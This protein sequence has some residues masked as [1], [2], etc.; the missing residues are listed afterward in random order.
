MSEREREE[1]R[2]CW[3]IKLKLWHG[4]FLIIIISKS[5]PILLLDWQGKLDIVYVTV[6][7]SLVK[8][9]VDW[10][11]SMNAWYIV[12]NT[13]IFYCVYTTPPPYH[14]LK[15]LFNN[16]LLTFICNCLCFCIRVHAMLSHESFAL[17]CINWLETLKKTWKNLDE[18]IFCWA[19]LI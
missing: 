2:V 10:N 14:L 5:C 11:T 9:H 16:F 3:H 17:H 4:L 6:H 18:A 19:C 13:N 15:E 8:N 12:P 7:M 1:K